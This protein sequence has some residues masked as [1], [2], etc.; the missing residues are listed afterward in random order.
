MTFLSLALALSP[1]LTAQLVGDTPSELN[2]VGVEQKLGASIPAGV[3]LK[4]HAGEAVALDGILDRPTPVILTFNYSTCPQ[5]CKLQ[6]EATADLLPRI[7]LEAGKDYQ[8]VT[9]SLNPEDV[10][11]GLARMRKKLL[12]RSGVGP[13][14]WLFLGGT[15]EQVAELTRSVGFGFAKVEGKSDY[16]HSAALIL[17]SQGGK[18]SRYLGG[19]SPEPRTLRLS[20]VEA[21]EGRAGSILDM[22]F[23]T[24]FYYD[25]EEGR[26]TPAAMMATRVGAGLGLLLLAGFVVRQSRSSKEAPWDS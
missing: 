5:L 4:N 13:S 10:P 3:V 7:G 14:A 6:L 16:A 1:A 22:A 11:E 9:V 19:L 12:E 21:S 26:Y 15:E 2:G 17:L 23:L 20:L 18:V 8:L 25:G 24:C